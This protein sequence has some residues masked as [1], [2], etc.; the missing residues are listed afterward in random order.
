MEKMIEEYKDLNDVFRDFDGEF[1]SDYKGFSM[2]MLLADTSGNIGY[3]L[4]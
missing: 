1:G 4:L 3:R 2:N